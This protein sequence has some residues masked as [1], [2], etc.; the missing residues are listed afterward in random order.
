MLDLLSFKTMLIFIT[1]NVVI[2]RDGIMIY[3]RAAV[4][5]EINFRLFYMSFLIFLN[6]N[7]FPYRGPKGST[8]KAV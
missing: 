7:I 8:Y 2:C 1:Y 4:R 5:F 6:I 3:E